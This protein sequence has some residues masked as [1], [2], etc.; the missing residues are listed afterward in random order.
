MH[1][2]VLT[3]LSME[4]ENPGKIYRKRRKSYD[5]N[6]KC[7]NY[8]GSNINSI[9]NYRK[10]FSLKIVMVLFHMRRKKPVLINCSLHIQEYEF[11]HS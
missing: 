3:C 8:Y 7:H 2:I 10:F 5:C 6:C 1:S 11:L 4:F 9:A